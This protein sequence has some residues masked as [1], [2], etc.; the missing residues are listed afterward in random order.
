MDS[1]ESEV[2]CLPG[3]WADHPTE[4]SQLRRIYVKYRGGDEMLGYESFESMM[5]DLIGTGG[6]SKS[7]KE[8][9][10]KSWDALNEKQVDFN[11]LLKVLSNSEVTP[12][13][14]SN[15]YKLAMRTD[16][17]ISTTCPHCLNGL[18][19]EYSYKSD[20]P[21]TE[22]R[23]SS[24]TQDP[25]Y[26]SLAEEISPPT[27]E[28]SSPARHDPRISRLNTSELENLMNSLETISRLGISEISDVSS[29]LQT[30]CRKGDDWLSETS[31]TD[32]EKKRTVPVVVAPSNEGPKKPK[33]SKIAIPPA[34]DRKIASPRNRTSIQSTGSSGSN[35]STK[36]AAFV[37]APPSGLS[38]LSARGPGE[39]ITAPNLSSRH[40][41]RASNPYPQTQRQQSKKTKSISS[42][43]RSSHGTTLKRSG[44]AAKL[45]ATTQNSSQGMPA[46]PP[47]LTARERPTVDESKTPLLQNLA[48]VV[49]RRT[50]KLIDTIKRVDTKAISQW[51]SGAE[52]NV[53][54]KTKESGDNLFAL[55]HLAI[56]A[57]GK[58][59]GDILSSVLTDVNIKLLNEYGETPF[60]QAA[61]CGCVDKLRILLDFLTKN[62]LANPD[63]PRQ[64][65]LDSRK[66]TPLHVAV[67][68][69]QVACVSL[70]LQNDLGKSDLNKISHYDEKKTAFHMAGSPEILSVLLDHDV[71]TSLLD[72]QGHTGLH[73]AVLSGVFENRESHVVLKRM[74]GIPSLVK[75]VVPQTGNTALHLAL[76]KKQ[77]NLATFMSSYGADYECQNSS[78]LTCLQIAQKQWQQTA[79][80][81][82]Q[83][84]WSALLMAWGTSLE[85]IT[86]SKGSAW[87]MKGA[88][89]WTK[90]DACHQNP[91]QSLYAT[92]KQDGPLEWSDPKPKTPLIDAVLVM[93]TPDKGVTWKRLFAHIP[94][95]PHPTQR[96]EI[97]LTPSNDPSCPATFEARHLPAI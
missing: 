18:P 83:L 46:P 33:V 44:S 11:T 95:T 31:D 23:R 92:I 2:G 16:S 54:M 9:R 97:S 28:A 51:V 12:E 14:V 3:V 86:T 7:R 8:L 71:E 68:H 36:S 61:R 17:T 77:T 34:D 29:M 35:K 39:G 58:G 38:P 43:K 4:V 81:P 45:F 82:A 13:I 96:V 21:E 40:A 32:S 19:P 65:F 80:T 30:L 10:L 69:S 91:T 76:E 70:L 64:Q 79:G 84:E 20:V 27:T 15:G 5:G 26:S 37:P 59:S 85:S 94:N 1:R 41:R 78:K 52:L 50:E 57:K 6:M 25:P 48:S 90:I 67:R 53:L 72:E 24:L 93:E 49:L 42:P 73:C 47:L 60:H 89:G 22:A 74:C 75:R 66:E 56:A 63:S 87:Y 55:P 62:R 88:F